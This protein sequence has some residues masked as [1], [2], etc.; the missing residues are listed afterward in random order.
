MKKHIFLI[1]LSLFFLQNIKA[2]A[3]SDSVVKANE[4]YSNQE[5]E[6][7]ARLYKSI[8]DAGYEAPE[9]YYNLG[10]AYFKNNELA[11]AILY[12]ERAK[13]LAPNDEQILYNLEIAQSRTMDRIE[14][15]PEIF[16]IR[17][18]KQIRQKLSADNWAKTGVVSLSLFFFILGIYY[19]TKRIALKKLTFFAGSIV[20]IATIVVFV[21]TYSQYHY[22]VNSNEAVVFSPSVTAK[23]SPDDN[24]TNLF[25]I[26]EG[27]KVIVEDEIEGWK[28]IRIADGSVGWIKEETLE[29]I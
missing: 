1:I 12:Y 11:S 6:L 23:S 18:W 7:A 24:S 28:E 13:K 8:V 15:V 3:F 22:Q 4:A 9:L 5:F 26:H 27:T 16:Y 29:S 10:N 17:W 19:F 2:D 25:V 21:L 20:L 14:T